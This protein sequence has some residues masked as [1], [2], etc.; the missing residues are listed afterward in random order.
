MH[1]KVNRAKGKPIKRW[2]RKAIGSKVY[3]CTMIAWLPKTMRS[4]PSFQRVG[5]YYVCRFL[6][7]KQDIGIPVFAMLRQEGYSMGFYT[8]K[9]WN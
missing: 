8:Y 1:S 3:Y 6:T 5:S 4:L 2:G 7:D 9:R